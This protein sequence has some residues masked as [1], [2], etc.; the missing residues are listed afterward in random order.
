MVTVY[1]VAKEARVST[2]TVSRVLNGHT[3]V[4]KS[5]Q[6]KVRIA[7]ERLNYRPH[8]GARSL[9][10]KRTD[11]IGM[12]LPDMYGEF[13]SEFIRGADQEA[14]KRNIH[15]LVH[16]SY[17]EADEIANA[18][19]TMYGKVDGAIIVSSHPQVEHFCSELLNDLPIVVVG[20]KRDRKVFPTVNL[21]NYLGAYNMTEH[22]IQQ[23]YRKVCVIGG[24]PDNCDAV[25]RKRGCF[26]AVQNLLSSFSVEVMDGDFT[27][28]SGYKVGVQIAE[29]NRKPQV[30]FALNDSMAIGCLQAFK[31]QNL[32]VPDDIALVG[33]DDIP[34]ARY[35]TPSLTTVRIPV[36]D[37]GRKSLEMIRLQIRSDRRLGTDDYEFSPELIIRDSS[38]YSA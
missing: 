32:I 20:G 14:R 10:I 3:S 33:F 31:E 7:A 8:Q 23:G 12:I 15:L 9:M 25:E 6:E 35:V 11:T 29:R 1:D 38:E 30:V 17:S 34:L 22:L 16:S 18:M 19:Q 26:H 28:A 24:P 36:T 2:A 27:E 37:M 21:D 13:F 4:A 5:L